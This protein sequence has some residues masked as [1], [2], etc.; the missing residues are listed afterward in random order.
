MEN[1]EMTIEDQQAMELEQARLADERAAEE[2]AS[3]ET[4]E[5]ETTEETAAEKGKKAKSAKGPFINAGEATL[6]L[7]FTGFM[8]LVQWAL[9][10]VPFLGWAINIAISGIVG[11]IVYIWVSGKIT[12]GA[13]KKWLKAIYYGAAG[14]A[15]PIIPGYCG[16]IIYLIYQ[17]RQFLGKTMGKIGEL[18]E[19]I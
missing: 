7:A 6:L 9:D 1:D 4:A 13:P 8:E 3:E 17:D 16:A 5:E 10:F 18:I 15:I 12:K 19:K 11:F 2:K 14:S